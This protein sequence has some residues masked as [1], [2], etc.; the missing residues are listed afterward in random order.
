MGKSKML[1]TF[2]LDPD[3]YH[4]R[5][6]GEGEMVR[7]VVGGSLVN[8]TGGFINS[9]GKTASRYYILFYVPEAAAK[10]FELSPEAFLEIVFSAESREEFG[11]EELVIK[12]HE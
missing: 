2:K 11:V 9:S 6:A 3:N 1:A 7:G 5:V 4:F 10:L 12:L 8:A